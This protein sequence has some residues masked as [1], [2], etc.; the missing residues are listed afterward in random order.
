MDENRE[1]KTILVVSESSS[2]T[3]TIQIILR[4]MGFEVVAASHTVELLKILEETE[5]DLI[6][7]DAVKEDDPLAFVRRVREEGH[8]RT[9]VVLVTFVSTPRLVKEAARFDCRDIV[10]KPLSLENLHSILQ[11]NI[12]YPGGQKRKLMRVP[13]HQQVVVTFGDREEETL[14]AENL[15][16]RGIYISTDRPSP[17]GSRIHVSV[18]L[19]RGILV[20]LDGTVVHTCHRNQDRDLSQPG[21][22]IRFDNMREPSVLALRDY[23]RRAVTKDLSGESRDSGID[24]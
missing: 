14:W 4:R 13:F 1:R 18:A 21:M 24:F 22:G 5:P 16:E 8:G 20:E 19:G 6:F 23:V 17:V 9:P 2:F 11:R 7:A 15:S 10:T 3:M 12:D